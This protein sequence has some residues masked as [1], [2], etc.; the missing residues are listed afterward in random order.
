MAVPLQACNSMQRP[1]LRRICE[2]V[3][4]FWIS[5]CRVGVLGGSS[6]SSG[7]R[8]GEG[9]PAVW[10]EGEVAGRGGESRLLGSMPL[11]ARAATADACSLSCSEQGWEGGGS[12][13]MAESNEL[14]CTSETWE[15]RGTRVVFITVLTLVVWRGGRG[16]VKISWVVLVG[17]EGR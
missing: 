9:E 7:G 3:R 12:G 1:T 14:M 4:G 15:V 13:T 2:G 8:R 11:A 10:R 6:S 17:R 5:L 16:R